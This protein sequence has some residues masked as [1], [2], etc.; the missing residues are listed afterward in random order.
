MSPRKLVLE[1][2]RFFFQP[3]NCGWQKLGLD[4]VT[5]A[6]GATKLVYWTIES[7]CAFSSYLILRDYTHLHTGGI[8]CPSIVIHF[9]RT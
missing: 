4:Q 3:L 2:P 9:F 1:T 8:W 7:G 6:V 5:A